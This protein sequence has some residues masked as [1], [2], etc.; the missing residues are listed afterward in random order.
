MTGTLPS[1]IIGIFVVNFR[2]L[3]V[4]KKPA[5]RPKLITRDRATSALCASSAAVQ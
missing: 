2:A 1:R 3:G 4:E 5:V